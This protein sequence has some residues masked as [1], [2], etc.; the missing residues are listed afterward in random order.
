MV[1]PEMIPGTLRGRI[2]LLKRDTLSCVLPAGHPLAD[3]DVI[4]VERLKQ[5]PLI[6]LKTDREISR[7][8]DGFPVQYEVSSDNTILSMVEVGLGISV[9][10]GLMAENCRYNVVW[11]PLEPTEQ[12]QIG[13]ATA[14][15]T[16][17]PSAARLFVEHVKETT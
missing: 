6:R 10:H 12:R 3:M 11:K 8:L 9:M 13:I 7:F 2:T 15:N 16:R 14:K 4:P 17:L 5:E 1:T